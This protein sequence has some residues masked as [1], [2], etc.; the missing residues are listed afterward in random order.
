MPSKIDVW[1]W[2]KYYREPYEA[3]LA[4]A[5]AATAAS[6]GQD[7]QSTQKPASSNMVEIKEEMGMFEQKHLLENDTQLALLQKQNMSLRK[8]LTLLDA[9]IAVGFLIENWSA[10]P[11]SQPTIEMNTGHIIPDNETIPSPSSVKAGS[12]NVGIIYQSEVLTG[13]S[14]VIRW[15][16]GSADLVLRYDFFKI[17]QCNFNI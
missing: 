12:Q 3:S 4:L 16:L 17:K 1:G 5:K 7:K 9:N 13:T 11:L 2:V 8:A 14:G 6:N 10:Y 15:T